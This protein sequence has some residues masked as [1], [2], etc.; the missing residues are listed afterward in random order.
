MSQ[1]AVMAG[2]SSMHGQNSG[3]SMAAGQH[4][5]FQGMAG[6]SMGGGN[7]VKYLET[8]HIMNDKLRN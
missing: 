4:S 8:V 5:G 6:R 3:A 2:Q 1:Q 7:C